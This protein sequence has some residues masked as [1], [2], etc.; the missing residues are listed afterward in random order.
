MYLILAR[1]RSEYCTFNDLC[2]FKWGFNGIQLQ[3]TMDL[4]TCGVSGRV[5]DHL[6]YIG[7]KY[8]SHTGFEALDT[9]GSLIELKIKKQTENS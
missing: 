4:I 7:L 9:L 3:N 2:A 8:S 1:F 5:N 6:Y